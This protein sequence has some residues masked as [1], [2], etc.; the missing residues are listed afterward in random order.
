MHNR[1]PGPLYSFPRGKIEESYKGALQIALE[2]N[3]EQG[4]IEID[5]NTGVS[6]IGMEAA[7]AV[8]LATAI[9][10]AARTLVEAQAKNATKN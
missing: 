10:A 6:W 5:F 2:V 8:T 9:L 3:H 4:I 1:R 7:E